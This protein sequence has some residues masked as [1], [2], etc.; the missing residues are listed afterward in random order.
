MVL[1]SRQKLW[2]RIAFSWVTIVLLILLSLL[3]ARSVFSMYQKNN[4]AR[5]RA[6]DAQIELT[7][8]EERKALL[9]KS[10]EHIKTSKGVEEEL[11]KKFDVAREGEHLLVIVDKEVKPEVKTKETSWFGGLWRKLVE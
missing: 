8:V 10:L 9:S 6:Q 7:K 4:R 3:L 1:R 11:R 5:E 2:H